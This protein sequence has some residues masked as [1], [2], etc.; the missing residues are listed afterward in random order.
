MNCDALYGASKID[1]DQGKLGEEGK[2]RFEA[3]ARLCGRD[4]RAAEAARLAK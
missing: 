1:A 3:F 4:S 2:R